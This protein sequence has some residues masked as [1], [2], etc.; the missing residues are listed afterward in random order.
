[1]HYQTHKRRRYIQRMFFVLGG[2]TMVVLLAILTILRFK[3]RSVPTIGLPLQTMLI[4]GPMGPVALKTSEIGASDRAIQRQSDTKT[5]T[6]TLSPITLSLAE[7]PKELKLSVPFAE[8]APKRI[9]DADHEDFCEEA[10]A[11]MVGR[12]FA[13]RSVGSADP[14]SPEATLGASD[15][16]AAL[17]E[18]KSWEEAHLS[19]WVSTTAAETARMIREVYGLKVEIVDLQTASFTSEESATDA[20][21]SQ[22]SPAAGQLIKQ[23][24]AEGKLVVVPAAGRKLGNPNFSNAGPLY[25]MLVLTGYT[26]DG[27]FITND[28]GIW[29]GKGYHYSA[30]VLLDA[31][32]DWNDGD[33]ENG[34][35]VVLIV[36]Q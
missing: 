17:Y 25:H 24:L 6:K 18:L 2:L 29:Q 15:I 19:T 1:M 13:G 27:Q 22:V 33:P 23:A 11:L 4:H 5:D 21:T 26:A 16:D 34:N 12:Y 35:K 36:S 10:S 28:P 3:Q 31:L 14:A 8:Q 20:A 9:W 30:S 7:L 32:G